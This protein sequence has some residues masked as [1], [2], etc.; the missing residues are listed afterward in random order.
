MPRQAVHDRRSQQAVF[1]RTDEITKKK[2][3]DMCKDK[4]VSVQE[5]LENLIKEEIFEHDIKKEHVCS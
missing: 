3:K 4:G 5:Y 2:L 1:F